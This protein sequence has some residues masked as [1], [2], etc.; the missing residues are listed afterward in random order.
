MP[1]YIVADH[2]ALMMSAI[3]RHSE[4]AG[5]RLYIAMPPRHGKSELCSVRLPAWYLGR[6]PHHQ[7]IHI[8]Y[9][10]DLSNDFSRRV[11]ALIRDSPRFKRIFPGVALDPERQRLNDW[12]TSAGGGF[13]SL[14]VGGGVTGHGADLMIIDDPHKE[15]DADSLTTLDGV[16]NWYVTAARTRLSPGASVIFLMTRWHLLD[17]AGR[18]LDADGSDEWERIVLP[19]LAGDN[20]LLGRSPG[21]ALW[22]GRYSRDDLLAI[23]ALDERQFQALF[24][25]NPLGSDDVFFK[26]S[27]IRRSDAAVAGDCFWTFDLATS[28]RES[29]D[30][31]VMSRWHYD[32]RVLHLLDCIRLREYFPLLRKRIIGL[33][34]G[35][36]TD[37]FVFPA[38]SLELLMLQE[39]V[40]ECGHERFFSVK[41]RGDKRQKALPFSVLVAAGRFSAAYRGDIDVFIS[42]LC[43]FPH[44]RFD[45]C[46]DTASLCVHYLGLDAEFGAHIT[47]DSGVLPDETV[48]ALFG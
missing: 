21:A 11:R 41:M 33:Y 10:A 48:T 12:K 45:D 30:Y 15:G 24:Q 18:L 28:E 46:V 6:Y 44:G 14:G 23:K 8:S 27:D 4:S 40:H 17:L 19:A 42:E 9:A 1:E 34:R 29:A 22:P 36:P 7:I 37:R 35:H 16:Y 43:R 39:L 3:Q 20:D 32:G 5:G 13:K 38:D 47:R 26:E 2:H 31:S 25:N